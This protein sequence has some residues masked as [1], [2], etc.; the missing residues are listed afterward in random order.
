MAQPLLHIEKITP[1][2]AKPSV[3]WVDTDNMRLDWAGNAPPEAQ[4]E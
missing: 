2:T 1:I 3:R 4:Q